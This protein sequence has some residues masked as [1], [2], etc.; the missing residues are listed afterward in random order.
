MD[1]EAMSA[2]VP[3]PDLENEGIIYLEQS[4]NET[5]E[6]TLWAVLREWG[7]LLLAKPSDED[8]SR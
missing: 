8:S 6:W 4:A 5:F 3:F 2:A 1:T 7:L